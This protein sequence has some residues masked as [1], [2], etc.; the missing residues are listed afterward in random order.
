MPR[1]TQDVWEPNMFRKNPVLTLFHEVS[2]AVHLSCMVFQLRT[3]QLALARWLKRHLGSAGYGR[4]RAQRWRL[5]EV[6]IL[7]ARHAQHLASVGLWSARHP[8]RLPTNL[9]RHRLL[10]NAVKTIGVWFD[11][12][13]CPAAGSSGVKCWIWSLFITDKSGFSMQASVRVWLP[14]TSLA[15]WTRPWPWFCTGPLPLFCTGP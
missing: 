6:L 12:W 4:G 7:P 5:L 3:V 11:D 8:A 14:S 10:R 2:R 15:H 1:K 9:S 13:S